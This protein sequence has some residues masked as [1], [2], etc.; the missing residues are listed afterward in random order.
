MTTSLVAVRP[1]VAVAARVPVRPVTGRAT[2][3]PPSGVAVPSA[4]T[5][6]GVHGRHGTGAWRP[7]A[8]HEATGTAGRRVRISAAPW[9][10]QPAATTPT[11]LTS[12][13]ST[14]ADS[15]VAAGMPP[16]TKAS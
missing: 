1:V 8:G 7:A 3:W 11:R 5:A 12:R 16:T 10:A 9:T 6:P 4:A 2:G 15:A 14:T 13:Y